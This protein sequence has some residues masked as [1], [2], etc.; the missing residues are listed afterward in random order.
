MSQRII[1]Q[2]L[3]PS[4]ANAPAQNISSHSVA[5]SHQVTCNFTD[6]LNK[7]CQNRRIGLHRSQYQT[8][9]R[10]YHIAGSYGSHGGYLEEQENFYDS[11]GY[12][13]RQ[14]NGEEEDEDT[15]MSGE[16]EG[17]Y[18]ELEEA[19]IMTL[20]NHNLYGCEDI[21]CCAV[22]MHIGHRKR[23]SLHN[24]SYYANTPPDSPLNLSR[25]SSLTNPAEVCLKFGGSPQ[26]QPLQ[27]PTPGD[28]GTE[29]SSPEAFVSRSPSAVLSGPEAKKS[30]ALGLQAN[31]R[32]SSSLSN[33]HYTPDMAQDTAM[34]TVAS[35]KN[36]NG[37]ALQTEKRLI[38]S[39]NHS[40]INRRLVRKTS[41]P[42]GSQSSLCRSESE[43]MRSNSVTDLSKHS[44]WGYEGFE[45]PRHKKTTSLGHS[46]FH[47][48]SASDTNLARSFSCR[49]LDQ[50][51]YSTISRS[52]S[53][54][55]LVKVGSRYADGLQKEYLKTIRHKALNSSLSQED[56]SLLCIEAEAKE[57]KSPAVPRTLQRKSALVK[58]QSVS[59]VS[60]QSGLIAKTYSTK[61]E[62]KATES[63][64]PGRPTAASMKIGALIKEPL[65][66]K[67]LTSRSEVV[68]AN[69]QTTD[70]FD[71][72]VTEKNSQDPASDTSR[73]PVFSLEVNTFTPK[74]GHYSFKIEKNALQFQAL[75][76]HI[77]SFVVGA[78]IMSEDQ[79][80]EFPQHIVK[81]H[82]QNGRRSTG[83]GVWIA[84]PFSLLKK[85]FRSS[86]DGKKE[87]SA[88]QVK[89]P[90]SQGQFGA[91]EFQKFVSMF[92]L[93]PEVSK[94]I[95]DFLAGESADHIPF[96]KTAIFAANE[97]A[98]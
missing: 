26:S 14:E 31:K 30:L 66:K 60:T 83:R 15:V 61:F 16:E 59:E 92:S 45:R 89:S 96:V 32:L 55:S 42:F 81:E 86:S 78:K 74:Y 29:L 39:V 65:V 47:G 12:T 67:L 80:P 75:Y 50:S 91:L 37:P 82:S 7:G 23:S 69:K 38:N 97:K 24:V 4:S 48:Y 41:S 44:T 1:Q 68:K 87:N 36:A 77:H 13:L 79:M 58:S 6:L 64:F 84:Q 51:T 9:R 5:S 71:V 2:E 70:F 56:V 35:R 18:E 73:V 43:D 57:N 90:P 46:K 21:E 54:A 10:P 28:S 85:L 34:R 72:S 63:V 88:V 33:L 76:A 53:K 17:L 27:C 19:H 62:N 40:A 98:I 93:V 22:R 95:V 25:S 11:N 49:S 20:K 94:Y 8:R 52:H 3:L